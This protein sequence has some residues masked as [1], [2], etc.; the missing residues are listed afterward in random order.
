VLLTGAGMAGAAFGLRW[1]GTR[2]ARPHRGL[3]AK[4][5]QVRDG[6]SRTVEKPERVAAKPTALTEI[7]TAAANA[8]VAIGIKKVLERGLERVLNRSVSR[9]P[10][11]VEARDPKSDVTWVP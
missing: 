2:R 1:L 6:L 4:A 3:L 9:R 7:L 10:F 8:A 11:L 5:H